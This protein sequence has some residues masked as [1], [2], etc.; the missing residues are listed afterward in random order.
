MHIKQTRT[1]RRRG[2]ERFFRMLWAFR[3]WLFLLM[4]GAMLCAPSHALLLIAMAQGDILI[5]G[6]GN[7][8]LDAD[9]N[10]RLDDGSGTGT[11][12]CGFPCAF[13]TIVPG[14][15]TVTISAW[16]PQTTCTGPCGGAG[17]DFKVAV[18]S[19]LNGTYDLTPISSCCWSADLPSAQI[20]SEKYG[21]DVFHSCSIFVES[22]T[23]HTISFC[24]V[25]STQWQL[26][27]YS[28]ISGA[29]AV[30]SFGANQTTSALDCA[31]TTYTL[32]N[33]TGGVGTCL[34]VGGSAS[35]TVN[36]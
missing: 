13:C 22:S 7:I 19:D 27:A 20:T 11:C 33:N 9:G 25:T 28:G 1:R 2:V 18:G 30:F 23:A 36:A 3:P 10:I 15:I 6:A 14:S 4:I 24:K 35:V 31:P 21:G 5:D 17:A 8:I 29:G 16:S 12:C 32:A 26:R 34:G